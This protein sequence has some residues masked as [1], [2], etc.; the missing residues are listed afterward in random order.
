MA[1]IDDLNVSISSMNPE[2]AFALVKSLRESRRIKK[3]VTKPRG[4]TSSGASRAKP[5]DPLAN[6]TQEQK[7]VLITMLEKELNGK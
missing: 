3:K 7:A 5:K 4:S 6:L 2:E 1:Q